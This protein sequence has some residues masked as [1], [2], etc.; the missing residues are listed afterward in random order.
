MKRIIALI[1]SAGVLLTQSLALTVFAQTEDTEPAASIPWIEV[2]PAQSGTDTVTNETADDTQDETEEQAETTPAPTETP[3]ADETVDEE[4]EKTAADSETP[5][6]ETGTDEAEGGLTVEE[7]EQPQA[8]GASTVSGLEP[9]LNF[10]AYP[11]WNEPDAMAN[12]LNPAAEEKLSTWTSR[13]PGRAEQ[14]TEEVENGVF[15]TDEE[16]FGVWNAET[17]SFE[18]EPMVQYDYVSP[19]GETLYDVE[20]AVI[21]APRLE[22]GSIDYS[23]AKAE[24]LEYHRNVVNLRGLEEPTID[25]EQPL[26]PPTNVAITL[27]VQ[28][29][30]FIDRP[31]ELQ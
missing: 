6:E 11:D 31:I 14:I 5:A 26:T 1:V 8:V 13:Y 22:D 10:D 3:A 15:P 7:G 4:A 19:Y 24:L 9:L 23:Q 20:Q 16:F 30:N 17:G 25:S 2:E 27:T 18:N 21:N 12:A 28:P 29:W